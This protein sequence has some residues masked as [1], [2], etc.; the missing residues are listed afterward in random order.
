M[1]MSG[2]TFQI[3]Y[4][5]D[6]GGSASFEYMSSTTRS[7]QD[8]KVTQDIQE[9]QVRWPYRTA[10]P[11]DADQSDYFCRE[12]TD[13]YSQ[14]S[15][16]PETLP[17]DLS[18]STLQL[19]TSTVWRTPA[20][21]QGSTT[22]VSENDHEMVLLFCPE[23]AWSLIDTCTGPQ[24][25]VLSFPHSLQFSINP[26]A[27]LPVPITSL[28]FSPSPVTAGTQAVGTVTLQS[29]ALLDTNIFLDSNSQ[30][31]TVLSSVI[32]RQGQSSA[33]FQVDTNNN[34]LDCNSNRD[35]TATIKASNIGYEAQEQLQVQ[36][37]CPQ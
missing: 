24:Q 15:C 10:T 17:N 23:N 11:V 9:P 18:I 33:T 2:V 34:G 5:Q 21:E 37:T 8:W 29:P 32:V 19:H 1:I 28:T 3:G 25:V 16:F 12:Q 20:V 13:L 31:A 26:G 7:I 6:S 14:V 22:I 36:N 30:N 4:T 35:T 27:V